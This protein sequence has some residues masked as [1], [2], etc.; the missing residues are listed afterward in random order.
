MSLSPRPLW[1]TG[2][3]AGTDADAAGAG[4]GTAGPLPAG[5]GGRSCAGD[6]VGFAGEQQAR[7]CIWDLE[8]QLTEA[9]ARSEAEVDRRAEA[10][11]QREA[12][13]RR[14]MQ[15]E[16]EGEEALEWL[17]QAELRVVEE[18]TARE[19][20]AGLWQSRHEALQRQLRRT[21]GSLLA[22]APARRAVPAA[23][24][25]GASAGAGAG[26]AAS[27]TAA[28]SDSSEGSRAL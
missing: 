1:S 23:A 15:A 8:R 5:R 13:E 25:H 4:A 9:V 21:E 6:A 24:R 27:A 3:A 17:R 22:Q 26:A 28:A 18:E 10:D 19:A 16:A 12:V 7:A 11:R 14:L 20:Q 2:I